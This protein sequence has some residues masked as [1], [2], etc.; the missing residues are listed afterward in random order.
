MA[1]SDPDEIVD[2]VQQPDEKEV[3]PEPEEEL[4]PI[5]EEI[6]IL[7]KTQSRYAISLKTIA[8]DPEAGIELELSAG[9]FS[10]DGANV[11]VCNS[12]E[13]K[14]AL[15]GAFYYALK[16]QEL[17]EGEVETPDEVQ[18][19]LANVPN[20]VRVIY[21]ILSSYDGKFAETDRVVVTLTDL[22][23]GEI[24]TTYDAKV[25][26]AENTTVLIVA[27]IERT[28]KHNLWG[29]HK[30]ADEITKESWEDSVPEFKSIVATLSNQKFPPLS[31]LYL[32]PNNTYAGCGRTL[33]TAQ[34]LLLSN[35]ILQVQTERSLPSLSY[36][37]TI[38]G[39][40][41]YTILV[42]NSIDKTITKRFFYSVSNAQGLGY[43]FKQLPAVDAFILENG[44]LV[45]G[46]YRGKPGYV[47][48]FPEEVKVLGEDD[49]PDDEPLDDDD[50][51][52][53]DPDAPPLPLF[54]AKKRKLLEIE[55]LA[56]FVNTV[57]N[58]TSL[59]PRRK[60]TLTP[61]AKIQVNTAFK[62]LSLKE[63]QNLSSYLLFRQPKR[64]ETLRGLAGPLTRNNP[65]FLDHLGQAQKLNGTWSL[66]TNFDQTQVRLR[67]L[68]CP[69][70]EF[71]IEVGHSNNFGSVY[72]GYGDLN[73]SLVFML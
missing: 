44:P 32:T 22:S 28:S 47:L 24:V 40:V 29:F 30:K 4:P 3:E 66:Q 14:N 31:S 56:Y 16:P 27:S 1:D 72:H 17:A 57:D 13:G 35:V 37:G 23:N 45:T 65:A 9:A 2:S 64:A 46:P 41:D 68:L 67:S 5:P 36:W 10:S 48:P 42:S 33:N 26:T 34:S 51:E 7:N 73:N 59:V 62:G 39:P 69:G 60:Y 52:D 55:R 20:S 71:V 18:V 58:H 12:D 43:K 38:Y 19:D 25:Q 70:A 63:A 49:E 11:A 6:I 21:Y 61:L 54:P 8:K 15:D 50:L 53:E